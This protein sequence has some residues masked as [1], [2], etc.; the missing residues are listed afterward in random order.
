MQSDLDFARLSAN[1]SSR[2]CVIGAASFRP[3]ILIGHPADFYLGGEGHLLTISPK[4]ADD[5]IQSMPFCV[6][7]PAR[8][9]GVA[10]LLAQ[11]GQALTLR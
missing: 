5:A 2:T 6:D 1:L 10:L 9:L 8:L 3:I 11:L 4:E 7:E